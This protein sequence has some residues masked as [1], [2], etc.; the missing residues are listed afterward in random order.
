MWIIRLLSSIVS[1]I[2]KFYRLNIVTEDRFHEKLV[3]FIPRFDITKRT[4]LS[5]AVCALVTYDVILLHFWKHATVA[6]M[7]TP[8]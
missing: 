4:W 5:L 8:R 6:D 1:D 7:T 2:S 3:L